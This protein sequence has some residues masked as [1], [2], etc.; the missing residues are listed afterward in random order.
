MPSP[1]H[2]ILAATA[3]LFLP[4][5]ASHAQDYDFS[6]TVLFTDSTSAEAELA[7]YGDGSGSYDGQGATYYFRHD[8]QVRIMLDGAPGG[9]AGAYTAFENIR[10]LIPSPGE[11]PTD[12]ADKAIGLR[13]RFRNGESGEVLGV[14]VILVRYEADGMKVT[15]RIEQG[16]HAG[17]MRIELEGPSS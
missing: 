8:S 12:P 16:D 6:G 9:A 11:A 13:A 5:L 2:R 7:F 10:E 1:V 4:V 17:I 3:L 14:G 15:R